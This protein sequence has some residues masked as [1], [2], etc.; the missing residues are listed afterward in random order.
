MSL[1]VALVEPEIPWNTGNIG[2]TCLATGADLHL[3]RPLGFSLED[4]YVKRAGLDYWQ[5]VKPRIWPTW[6][7]FD[8]ALPDLGEP[9]FFSAEADR[10]LWSVS[11]PDDPVLIFGSETSGLP[12]DIRRD[13]AE[14]L[15]AIPMCR[16]P[17]R[18]L[19]LSTAAA[20]AVYEAWRQISQPAGPS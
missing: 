7:A 13:Y 17:V 11:F 6:A 5:Y 1:Q 12:A 19:N 20:I 14:R 2:R 16:S 3:I 8:A 18:S 15:I 4:R 9:F 10:D